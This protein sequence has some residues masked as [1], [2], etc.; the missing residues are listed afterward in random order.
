MVEKRKDW[1]KAAIITGTVLAALLVFVLLF[2][3]ITKGK[4]LRFKEKAKERTESVISKIPT[5]IIRKDSLEKIK[6]ERKLYLA[7]LNSEREEID[8]LKME[9][10]KLELAVDS[11]QK[12]IAETKNLVPKQKPKTQAPV[13]QKSS[14]PSPPP[15]VDPYTDYTGERREQA[16]EGW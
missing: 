8:S 15:Q 5:V 3:V 12:Q 9:K 14:C 6:A 4:I 13:T 1:K 2:L 7:V 16:N 11:L 10:A